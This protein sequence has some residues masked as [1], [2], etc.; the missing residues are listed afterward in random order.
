[1]ATAVL[2]EDH[3][4]VHHLGPGVPLPDVV[5]MADDERPALVVISVT[6]PP[7]RTLAQELAAQLTA[8]GR[9]VL[10]GRPGLTLTDLVVLARGGAPLQEVGSA[11]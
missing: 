3:W 11:S 1:M 5:H 10:V 8:P 7:A 2:R 9:R 6:W 4:Q